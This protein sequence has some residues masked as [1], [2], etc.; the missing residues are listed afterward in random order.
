VIPNT[1]ETIIEILKELHKEN[2]AIMAAVRNK[3]WWETLLPLFFTIIGLAFGFLTQNFFFVRNAKK[4]IAK[5]T[6]V[7][8]SQFAYYS[9][10]YGFEFG[11]LTDKELKIQ[12]FQKIAESYLEISKNHPEHIDKMNAKKKAENYAKEIDYWLTQN[13]DDVDSFAKAKFNCMKVLNELQF[14]LND[15]KFDQLI[16]MYEGIEVYYLEDKFSLSELEKID[17]ISFIRSEK[18]DPLLNKLDHAQI[19]ILKYVRNYIL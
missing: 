3:P 2:T 8:Y 12:I 17:F 15:D 16:N 4:E 1:Q 11:K 18:I 10:D 9:R 13:E 7:L 6:R 19:Q 5:D 14:L